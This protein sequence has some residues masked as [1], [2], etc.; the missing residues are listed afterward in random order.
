[1][2]IVTADDIKGMVKAEGLGEIMNGKRAV[3]RRID[4][5]VALQRH[6]EEDVQG[7]AGDRIDYAAV[8]ERNPAQPVEIPVKERDQCRRGH[9]FGHRRESLHVREQES[10]GAGR[11]LR[12][13]THA[14]AHPDLFVE[15]NG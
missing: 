15:R 12:P 7:I 10:D 6:I 9:P 4:M 13:G 1:M 8:G 11:Q 3:E 2:G 14:S 5:V